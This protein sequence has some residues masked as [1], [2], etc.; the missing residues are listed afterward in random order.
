MKRISRSAIVE[1]S[2]EAFYALAEDVESYPSFL[3]WCAAAEVRERTPGRTVATLT[4]GVKGVR[5][6]FTTENTNVPGRSIDMQLLEGPF[7]HFSAAW[8]FAPLGAN[9]VKV[10]FSLAYEFSSRIVAAALDP[11]FS[12]IA[13]STVDAFTKRIALAR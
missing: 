9:A 13:D 8:R 10:E 11:V 12:R 7:K 2:A 6:S 5:Q 3:P 1:S 4:L